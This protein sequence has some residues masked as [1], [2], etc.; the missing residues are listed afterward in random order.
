MGNYIKVAVKHSISTLFRR[1]WSRRRI[2]RELG[3]DRK[4]IGRYIAQDWLSES[5]SA[6]STAGEFRKKAL[7]EIFRLKK[8][9]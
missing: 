5:K 9:F 4:T 3:I 8:Q 1:G 2:A 6:I 7:A